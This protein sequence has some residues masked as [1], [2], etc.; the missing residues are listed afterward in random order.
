MTIGKGSA[1]AVAF[2]GAIGFGALVGQH[3]PHRGATAIDAGAASE[4]P[5]V[6]VDNQQTPPGARRT[7]ASPRETKRRTPSAALRRTPPGATERIVPAVAPTLHE[8]LKPVL[9]KGADMDIASENFVDGEQFAAVAHA[10]R[11][12]GVPFMVL[13]H[14][15]LDEGKSLEAAI[16]EYKPNLNAVV[17]ARRAQ[18]EAKSDIR[19]LMG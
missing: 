4:T 7:T 15:V 6:S 14:R 11:N 2:V 3:I 1:L 19:A 13:K 12:T 17:E 8:V 18:A 9:N 5:Q 16:R 10:A